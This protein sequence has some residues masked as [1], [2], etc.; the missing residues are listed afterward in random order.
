MRA[1]SPQQV[2]DRAV[3]VSDHYDIDNSRSFCV[4]FFYQI[5]S[6]SAV[7]RTSKLEV[8]QT[9]DYLFSSQGD[10]SLVK[11]IAKIGEVGGSGSTLDWT[12]FNVT[13]KPSNAGSVNMWFYLVSEYA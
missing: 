3:L 10:F 13:A 8:F 5:K 11:R 1:Q 9:D 4:K 7:G 2:G 6:Q 12:Q